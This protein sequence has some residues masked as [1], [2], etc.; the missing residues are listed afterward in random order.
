MDDSIFSTEEHQIFRETFRKF[1]A[2]E[3]TPNVSK[4]EAERA[5]PREHLDPNG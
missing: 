4:W 3:I 5:V 2:R 1:V